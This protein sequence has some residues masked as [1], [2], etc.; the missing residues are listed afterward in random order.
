VEFFL[1]NFF[2]F[3]FQIFFATKK[4]DAKGGLIR[5]KNKIF[6]K[7]KEEEKVAFF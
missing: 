6:S 5:V 7:K 2:V 1:R 4:I 3:Q